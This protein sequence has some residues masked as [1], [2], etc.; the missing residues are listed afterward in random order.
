MY[1]VYVDF[2][3]PKG[4]W[5]PIFSWL[6]RLFEWTRYSHVRIRWVN[7]VGK[8]LIYEASGSSVKMIGSYA[9]QQNPILVNVHHT[10]EFELD[11]E[12][13][14]KLISLLD[15]AYVHY[16]AWQI[17]GIAAAKL[18]GLKK[19]P[20]PNGKRTMICS[21]LVAHFLNNVVGIEIPSEEFDLI[22]PRRIKEILDKRCKK[23][24]VI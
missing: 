3:S 24:R 15:Y 19:N 4:K 6:V 17:V 10:Y 1:R 2:T 23:Q 21:E 20:F 8:E 22:G 9:V 14:R 12:Q 13:Y 18:F 16:G 5:F 7:S 11:R